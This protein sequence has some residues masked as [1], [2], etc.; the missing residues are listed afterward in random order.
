MTTNTDKPNDLSYD[1]FANNVEPA[2]RIG[3]LKPNLKLIIGIPTVKR[4]VESY[5]NRTLRSLLKTNE[6]DETFG[7]LISIGETDEEYIN[8]IGADIK[9]RFHDYVKNGRI[10]IISPSKSYYPNFE[11][12]NSLNTLNDTANR[13]V[14]RQKQNLDYVFLWMNCI[15]R[16]EYFIQLE[17]D[18]NAS[19][20]YLNFI[21][22]KISNQTSSWFA[23]EFCG[24][25]FIGKLFQTESLKVNQRN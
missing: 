18:V 6:N 3:R 12:V 21:Y 16:S 1:H 11:K 4:K 15:G 19:I 22:H 13:V 2:I 10:E 8:G 7:I 5:L 25:G 17:D 14:W 24:L 9:A 23:L 20:N